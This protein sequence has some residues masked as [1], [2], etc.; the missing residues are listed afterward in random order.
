MT[1]Q[2]II[3][4]PEQRLRDDRNRALLALDVSYMR[5]YFPGAPESDLLEAMHKARYHATD[6]ARLPRLQSAQWLRDRHMR[7]ALGE[8]ILPEGQLPL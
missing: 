6:L 2:R 5:A 1:M 7:D 8:P 3:E 4:T